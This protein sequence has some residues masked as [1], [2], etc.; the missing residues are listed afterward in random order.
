MVL[1][2]MIGLEIH[3]YLLTK[4][5]LF[6]TCSA[7]R[8]KGLKGNVNI[9][10]I[11]A[12]Q[13]GSKPML[14]NASAVESA[15]KVGLILGCKIQEK[16]PWIRKHYDWP[17]SPKG[18]QLTLS[19]A[20]ST[21]LG[22]G[23]KYLGIRV[24]SMHLEEDPAAWDP[25]T[26]EVDYNRSGLPLVEIVTEPDFKTSEEVMRWLRKLVHHL[27]YLGVVDSNA[28][29]KVDVNV[30]I[31]G[32][33]ER[34]EVK[35]VSSI[36]EIGRAIEYE[37]ERQAKEGGVR[38]TRRFDS[39]KGVSVRMRSKEEADDYRFIA[40]PDLVV[41]KIEKKQ[42][43]KIRKELPESPDEMLE[44][45][46]KKYKI[47]EK[48]AE[49]LAKNLDV[50]VF[51]EKVV[52]K[53]VD[54]KFALPWVVIELLRHL[55]YNKCSLKEVEIKVED[56]ASLLNLV[57]SGKIT[58][59]QGKQI[60]NKFYPKSFDPS[61]SVKEKIS[62]EKEILEFVKKA[63]AGNKK[64]VEDFKNGDV[65]ALNFLLGAVMQ[66]SEKRADFA[67]AKKLLEKALTA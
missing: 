1:T 54:A 27:S 53:G 66:L 37:F 55:N 34:V 33:S 44:N 59:Q 9:C 20:H 63:I 16:M 40:D 58:E 10:A 26:G 22:I 18:Y 38:E 39:V 61:K 4:E 62:D 5:K 19:G 13:P 60:L 52:S 41:L 31:P 45:L 21:P 51:Y 7:S 14:P 35:N 32:K 48:S 28:G 30:N 24:R 17:D 65:K 42:V 49:V 64:A 3:T 43:E 50:A 25:E 12:G 23:G 2:G 6:C 67:V 36:E 56:F 15:I 47:D 46:V 8:E 29:V 11:C 57:K